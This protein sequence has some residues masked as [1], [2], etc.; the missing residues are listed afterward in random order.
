MKRR[1]GRVSGTATKYCA[2]NQARAREKTAPPGIVA[3]YGLR[4]PGLTDSVGHSFIYADVHL[5]LGRER[6]APTNTL[7][8]ITLRQAGFA[9]CIDSE[10]MLVE[11]IE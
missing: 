6:S 1:T 5:G 10:H 3:K 8:T 7:S 9:E 2:E 4:S 11:R